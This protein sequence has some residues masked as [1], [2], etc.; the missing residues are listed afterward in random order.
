MPEI[1]WSKALCP[2]CGSTYQYPE[3]GYKPAT[4]GRWDCIHKNEE[5]D[6]NIMARG[7]VLENWLRANS[8]N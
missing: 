1:K 6:L 2:I 4:C 8:E 7:H 3:D 5:H